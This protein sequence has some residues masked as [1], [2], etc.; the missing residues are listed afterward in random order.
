MMKVYDVAVLGLADVGM[1]MLRAALASDRF[2]VV[3]VADENAQ[4]VRAVADE[5]GVRGYEDF[6]SAVVEP[7]RQGLDLVLVALE[8]HQ[9]VDVLPLIVKEN[10]A[11]L[12]KV[13]FARSVKEAKA[14]MDGFHS[15]THPLFAARYWQFEQAFSGLVGFDDRLRAAFAKIDAPV[16]DVSGWRGDRATAGGGVLLCDAY[17]QIDLIVQAMGMPEQVTALCSF[18]QRSSS[19]PYDTE[20]AA[21]LVLQFSEGRSA[22]LTVVRGVPE[23]GWSLTLLG[24]QRTAE[25]VSSRFKVTDRDTGAEDCAVM[26]SE[27]RFAGQLAHIAACLDSE[28]QA[29]QSTAADH[30]STL[31]VIETAYLSARTGAPEEPTKLAL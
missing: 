9:S 29:R 24:S 25:V 20:D 4:A 15:V 10:I 19:R 13:P 5:F 11:A 2:A 14:Q 28:G 31:A 1:E 22:G 6:R 8:P 30:L 27:H 23:P 16:P 26:W 12:H 7:A 3:A 17:E 21:T 18:V